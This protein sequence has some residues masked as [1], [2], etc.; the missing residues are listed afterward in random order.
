MR[1]RKGPRGFTLVELMIVVVIL[2][3]LATVAVSSYKR[4]QR[5]A[6]QSEGIAAINDIRMKQETFYNTYSTYLS[7]TTDEGTFTGDLETEL[8][9]RGFYDWPIECPNAEEVWCQLGFD[10]PT[11]RVDGEQ[12]AYF[13]FQT[14]GW[15]PGAD[16]PSFISNPEQRWVSAA[17]R[18]VPDENLGHCVLLRI[19]NENRE[20]LTLENQPC[21]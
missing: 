2:S 4:Y 5:S 18:G 12:K 21:K 15:S 8:R 19:S 10:P 1:C 3:I 17:A 11:H 9:Y 20:A 7:S 6:R 14:M 16:A 13:Q